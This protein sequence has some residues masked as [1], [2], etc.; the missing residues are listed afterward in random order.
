MTAKQ[1][2][3][4]LLKSAAKA[5]RSAVRKVVAERKLLG[6]PVLVWK[7]GKVVRSSAGKIR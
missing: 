1:K 7:N 3:E 6:Q 2:N 5:M 4:L